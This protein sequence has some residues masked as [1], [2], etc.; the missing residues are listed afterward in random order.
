MPSRPVSS[1]P[2][3]ESAVARKA[4]TR[5][6]RSASLFAAHKHWIG[7]QGFTFTLPADWN[8]ASFG[9]E[10]PKGTLR[11]DDGDGPRIELR[12]ETPQAAVDLEKSIADFV[13]RLARDAKKKKRSFNQA[14]HPPIV[15]KSRKPKAQLVN[16]G[17]TS[18]NAEPL[19]A[20][21]WGTAWQC[22]TCGRVVVAHLLGRA[23]EKPRAAQ[24]MASEIFTSLECH[25]QGGWQAWGVFGLSAEIPLDFALARAKLQTGR[26]EIEWERPA[27]AGLRGLWT[28]PERLILRRSSAANLLLENESLEDWTRRTMLWL[29][30]KSYWNEAQEWSLKDDEGLSLAGV[31][32]PF[33]QRLAYALRSKFRWDVPQIHLHIW[34]DEE[35]NK[36]VSL[37]SELLPSNAHVLQDV[38]DSLEYE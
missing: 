6:S 28:R 15:Q 32:K 30:K 13:N 31:P 27:P 3:H 25:G 34:H 4:E 5:W 10:A 24:H 17:W 16:F 18:D 11:V 37:E 35:T 2:S 22:K 21:G 20:H 29:D 14:S 33:K 9:G 23:T 8:L 1:P 12:W 26:L 7:W 36:I 38:L 19:A